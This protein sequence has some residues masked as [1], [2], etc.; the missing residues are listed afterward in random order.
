MVVLPE[1]VGPVTSTMPYG[2]ATASINS[3][4]AR[5]SMPNFSRS[6]VRLPLSRIRSTTFSP[7]SV[8]SVDTRKSMTFLPD[9]ELDAPVLRH[10]ALGDVELR[11]DLEARDERRLELHR[12]LHHFLQRAVDAVAHADL[13]LEALEVD[14][15]CALLHGVGQDG[16]DQ[17]HDRRIVDRG[18]EHRGADFLFLF[19]DDLDVVPRRRCR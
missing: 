11:H 9:L 15:R 1:P 19:L 5:G 8:G 18:G 3:R 12:R 10:A 7:N 6:S 2:F 16:V 14:V 13:V 17:L 4:S